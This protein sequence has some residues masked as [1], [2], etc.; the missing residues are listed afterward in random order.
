M[1]SRGPFALAAHVDEKLVQ[2]LDSAGLAVVFCAEPVLLKDEPEQLIGSDIRVEYNRDIEF[3][4][5][6][7]QNVTN[8]G[9]LAGANLAGE[10]DQTR[11]V[12]KPEIETGDGIFVL[13]TLIKIIG[14]RAPD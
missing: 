7:S 12:H 13:S 2:G 5:D 1:M 8:N 10:K 9:G 3:V 6:I 11:V 14:I 4:T